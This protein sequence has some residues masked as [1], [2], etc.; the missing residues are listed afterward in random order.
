MYGQPAIGKHASKSG[1]AGRFDHSN[2][3]KGS[4]TLTSQFDHHQRGVGRFNWCASNN[5][6]S[7]DRLMINAVDLHHKED[8][9][10]L[11]LSLKL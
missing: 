7:V 5:L 8:I 11:D 4:L 3:N 10:K 9:R 2:S 1:G 6:G